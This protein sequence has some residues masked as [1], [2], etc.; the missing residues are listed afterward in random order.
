MNFTDSDL[1]KIPLFYVLIQAANQLDYPSNDRVSF[2]V[3][4]DEFFEI[5]DYLKQRTYFE[6]KR[7][8]DVT[9]NQIET[10]DI[11][12]N[13]R[14]P[15]ILI[16]DKLYRVNGFSGQVF[17][18]RDEILG[19]SYEWTIEEAKK[20]FFADDN[21]NRANIIYFEWNEKDTQNLKS[22]KDAIDKLYSSD[23]KIHKSLDVGDVEQN[24]VQDFFNLENLKQFNGTESKYTQLILKL[25]L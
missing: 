15:Q 19:V 5:K 18:D 13:Y 4:Y 12:G 24:M 7:N 10:S 2:P 9:E 17:S 16:D 21:P 25:I 1:E 8:G 3:S 14:I 20:N 22:V 11:Y 6:I 23:D